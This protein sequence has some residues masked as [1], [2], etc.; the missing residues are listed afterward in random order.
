MSADRK[1]RF[2]SP[3]IFINELDQSQLPAA[4]E[5]VGPVIIGRTEKGPGMIP[6][7]VNSFSE[8]VDMIL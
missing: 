5:A 7:K 2:V 3:G 8:F 4:A 1:F 6:V